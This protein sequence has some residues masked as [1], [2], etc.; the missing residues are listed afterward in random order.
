[1]RITSVTVVNAAGTI[2][3][4]A[5]TGAIQLYRSYN[6]LECGTFP[7]NHIPDVGDGYSITYVFLGSTF[8]LPFTCTIAG[9]VATFTGAPTQDEELDK[10]VA[11]GAVVSDDP[12]GEY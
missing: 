11:L 7:S 10:L 8:T 4:Q 12:K 2:L 1:M 5:G 6:Q 3:L 9:G